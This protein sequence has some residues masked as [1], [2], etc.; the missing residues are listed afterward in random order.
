M[1]REF[2][3]ARK[4]VK[5]DIANYIIIT[6]VAWIVSAMLVKTFMSPNHVVLTLCF[7]F[8]IVFYL[9]A[10]TRQFR[11]KL[12]FDGN[13]ISITN[14]LYTSY[15]CFYWVEVVAI[16]VTLCN[17]VV[18][19]SLSSKTMLFRR[20]T[21]EY[22]MVCREIIQ[23]ALKQNPSIEINAKHKRRLKKIGVNYI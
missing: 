18:L 6:I 13:K 9:P 1:Y 15:L 7:P 10:Y 11:Y 23:I 20:I 17:T 19:R 14:D 16:E 22:V 12:R 2:S 21:S 5:Y 3:C 4:R 8:L